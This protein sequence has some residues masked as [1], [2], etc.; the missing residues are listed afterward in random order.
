[1]PLVVS[2]SSGRGRSA[3]DP[4]RRCSRRPRR[5][6]GSPPV[7]RTSRDAE[8]RDRDP[9]QPDDLV[10][11][12]QLRL[13]QPVEALGRHA[14]GAAQVAPVG[15][16]DAQ[17]ACHPAEPVDQH[18]STIGL[19]PVLSAPVR[20]E[21]RPSSSAGDPRTGGP[22]PG[23]LGCCGERLPGPRLD[24][25]DARPR[26]AGV[27]TRLPGPARRALVPAALALAAAPPRRATRR[28]LPGVLAL[29]G[30]ARRD[31]GRHDGRRRPGRSRGRPGVARR[32]GNRP[33]RRRRP[34]W[35]GG[36]R[37][38]APTASGS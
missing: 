17:V 22:A 16:R 36:A 25:G 33:L 37:W 27:G 11:G 10:V 13:G 18:L 32:D 35:C 38:T 8:Q 30:R 29:L 19:R 31:R 23:S 14:V 1:M 6:S 20:H 4:R 34:S 3:A 26:P 15:Q 7:S 12:Q 9:H 21:R 2:D 28:E 24:D 5:S